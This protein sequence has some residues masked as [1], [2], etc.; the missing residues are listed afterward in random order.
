MIRVWSEPPDNDNHFDRMY[1]ACEDWA[2]SYDEALETDRLSLTHVQPVEETDTEHT[3]GWWRF[4]WHEDATLLLD[5]LEADLQAEVDW[6]RLK[7]HV[8]DHDQS[9]DRVGCSWDESETREFG[10]I[11][12]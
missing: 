2:T 11:P 12:L 6:Y 5:D 3:T 9:E 7:Y 1:Q 8:C 4:A 10:T